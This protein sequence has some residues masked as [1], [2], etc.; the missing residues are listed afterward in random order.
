MPREGQYK[1][2]EIGAVL[3]DEDGVR[4]VWHDGQ[5]V[6]WYR[7]SDH[8]NIVELKHEMKELKAVVYDLVCATIVQ[9]PSHSVAKNLKGYYLKH[10]ATKG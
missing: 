6:K 9:H 4:E 10:K 5:W 2:D 1:L 7:N 8:K 3:E